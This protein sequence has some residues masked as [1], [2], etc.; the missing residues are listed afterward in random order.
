MI[1]FSAFILLAR[2]ENFTA[3]PLS[4]P[5][6]NAAKSGHDPYKFFAGEDAA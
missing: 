3:L 2:S 6:I 5:C 1:H 4:A